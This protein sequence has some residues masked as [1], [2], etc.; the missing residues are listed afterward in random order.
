MNQLIKKSL[1]SKSDAQLNHKEANV[2]INTNATRIVQPITWSATT[3][4]ERTVFPKFAEVAP[5]QHSTA[6][7]T[8]LHMMDLTPLTTPL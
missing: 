8:V 7:F 4:G 1:P 2:T 3:M 5:L 6:K